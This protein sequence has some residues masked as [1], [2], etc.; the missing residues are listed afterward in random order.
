VHFSVS[1]FLAPYL[2]FLWDKFGANLASI[3]L[4]P[5][6]VTAPSIGAIWNDFSEQH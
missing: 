5:D 6:A 3:F 2:S 1:T 4:K